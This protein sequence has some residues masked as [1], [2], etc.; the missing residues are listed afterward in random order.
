[1][2]RPGGYYSILEVKRIILHVF[3][4]SYLKIHIQSRYITQ[5]ALLLN[6]GGGGKRENVKYLHLRFFNTE[7]FSRF[8]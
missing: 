7:Y 3:V 4:C 1:M 6:R 5:M 8:N 2:K